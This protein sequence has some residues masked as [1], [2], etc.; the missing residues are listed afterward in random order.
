MEKSINL[1]N[2]EFNRQITHII[3]SSNLPIVN[4]YQSLKLIYFE[5]EKLYYGTINS[6]LL[7]QKEQIKVQ[8][9]ITQEGTQQ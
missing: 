8:N 1:L 3:N 7:E 6:E 4:I 5:I 2:D 9:Q